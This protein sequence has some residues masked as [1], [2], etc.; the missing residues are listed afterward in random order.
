[1]DGHAFY[2]GDRARYFAH[3]NVRDKGGHPRISLHI[4][5]LVIEFCH[6]E[7]DTTQSILKL[8]RVVAS[9]QSTELDTPIGTSKFK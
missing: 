4:I 2:A 3:G 7:V 8:F 5:V 6:W 9:A 1:M